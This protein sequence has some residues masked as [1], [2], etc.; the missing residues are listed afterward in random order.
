MA[1]QRSVI[2]YA[3]VRKVQTLSD[4][5]LRITLDLAESEIYTAAWMMNRHR[6]GDVLLVR[7]ERQPSG[8]ISEKSV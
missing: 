3:E 4:N 1:E 2:F 5:G 6:V 7:A 8:N